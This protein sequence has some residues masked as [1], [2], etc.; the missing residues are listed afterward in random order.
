VV[1]GV[2]PLM[3]R[4]VTVV[5]LAVAMWAGA[6]C[7]GHEDG[8]VLILAPPLVRADA[9]WM[10]AARAFFK[11]ERLS[12]TVRWMSSGREALQAW[13]QAREHKV[14]A[15]F[16]VVNEMLALDTW[17]ST[18]GD[19]AVV[20]PLARDGDSYVVV[21]KAAVRS[22]DALRGAAVATQLGSTSAWVLGE[23]LR[24]H[25]M[26]ERDVALKNEKPE[27]IL[28][29]EPAS[30]EVAA[31]VVREPFATQALQKHGEAVHRLTTGTAYA[32]GYLMLGTSRR[33]LREHPGV[34]ERLLRALDR[35][36]EHAAAQPDDVI[37]FARDMFGKDTTLVQADYA[38]TERLLAVDRTAVS[39]LSNLSR[40]MREAGLLS[41]GA[42][43]RDLFELGPLR[44]TFPERVTTDELR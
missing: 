35:G 37:L 21:A 19:F 41:P 22:P 29:W 38:S 18:G 27:A 28:T 14:G 25:G 32:H 5:A 16:V 11:D 44:A 10:A 30:G 1:I 7:A 20:A 4:S 2:V 23:Y 33:Y 17:Q 34:A 42:N 12:V 9:L 39:D 24:A 31:F 6:A 40:W 15:A 43:P 8:R 26:S 36:R 3:C 13:A